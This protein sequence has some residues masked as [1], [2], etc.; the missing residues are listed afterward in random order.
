MLMAYRQAFRRLPPDSQDLGLIWHV[1]G[2]GA[3]DLLAP[4]LEDPPA[5]PMEHTSPTASN[6]PSPMEAPP[7]SR[8]CQFPPVTLADFV[9]SGR[10]AGAGARGSADGAVSLCTSTAKNS[11]VL[12]QAASLLDDALNGDDASDTAMDGAAAADL[13]RSPD[14]LQSRRAA[15]HAR[16]RA[17]VR[18]RREEDALLTPARP[19]PAAVAGPVS[20]SVAGRPCVAAS[21]ARLVEDVAGLV[22]VADQLLQGAGSCE[23]RSVQQDAASLLSSARAAAAA[24]PAPAA[25]GADIGHLRSWQSH[26]EELMDLRDGVYARLLRL[27][28]V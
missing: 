7:G 13:D 12:A 16:R 10:A 3:D 4:N 26:V 9:P 15:A 17:A 19:V 14:G 27:C 8:R 1:G 23:V 28:N 22:R 25:S 5:F 6:E 11:S 2:G 24:V 18:R 21:V 20:V